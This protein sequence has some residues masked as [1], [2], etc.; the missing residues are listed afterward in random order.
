VLKE[1]A[2]W[3]PGQAFQ[4][5]ECAPPSAH[6]HATSAVQIASIAIS[7]AQAPDAI[8][9][10]T[11]PQGLWKDYESSRTTM[12][13]RWAQGLS[14]ARDTSRLAMACPNAA[15][16]RRPHLRRAQGSPPQLIPRPGGSRVT[17]QEPD[18]SAMECHATVSACVRH[19]RDQAPM[20]ASFVTAHQAIR[21]CRVPRGIKL[22]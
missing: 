4:P 18:R 16:G 15:R 14:D 8:L 10:P 21:F 22:G 1:G 2:G 17:R 6:E 20:P 12:K 13:S 9:R 11:D 19:A 5:G 3:D 7:S